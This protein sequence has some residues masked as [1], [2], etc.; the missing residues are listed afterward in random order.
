MKKTMLLIL[1]ALAGFSV[2]YAKGDQ[3]AGTPGTEAQA[4]RSDTLPRNETLY[5]NGLQWGSINGWNPLSD[6]TN[7]GMA[8]SRQAYGTR[9]A[10]FEPLYMFNFLDNSMVP[11]LADGDPQ[12]NAA[13]TEVTVKIKKAAKWSDGTPVT[14]EDVAYTYNTGVKISNSAGNSNKP[15]IAAVEAVDA[16][17]LLIKAALNSDGSAKNPLMIDLFLTQEYVAQKAWIQTLEARSG[18]DAGK[19]KRDF[20][21]DAVYC[22]MMR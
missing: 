6:D 12:W 10:M 2:L 21:E 16:N 4:S 15:Y 3:D 14:A 20:A 9:I 1:L 19:M 11:L 22:R 18:G 8:V 17:T 13:R 5:F 7:N